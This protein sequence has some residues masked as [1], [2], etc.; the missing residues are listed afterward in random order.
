MDLSKSDGAKFVRAH[1][2]V[3]RWGRGPVT[4]DFEISLRVREI[5]A[6]LLQEARAEAATRR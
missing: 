3:A 6:V 2:E 1:W 4:P 5:P